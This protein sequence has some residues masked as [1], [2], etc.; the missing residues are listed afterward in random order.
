MTLQQNGA[1]S[2]TGDFLIRKVLLTNAV[3][4]GAC[5]LLLL[6]FPK[7]VT[8]WTGLDNRSALIGTGIFLLIVVSFLVWAATK[9]VVPYRGVL[10]FSIVDLLWVVDSILLLGANGSV[11]TLTVFGIWAIILVAV[12]VGIFAIFEASYCWRNRLYSK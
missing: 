11:V 10:I 2:V 5:G 7:Y 6:L 3:S 8:D 9:K 12:V 4:S 1:K